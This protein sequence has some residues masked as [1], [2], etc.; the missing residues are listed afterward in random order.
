MNGS[1]T[2]VTAEP[3]QIVTDTVPTTSG[4]HTEITRKPSKTEGMATSYIIPASGAAAVFVAFIATLALCKTRRKKKGQQL[5]MSEA[6][7]RHKQS[8]IEELSAG[9]GISAALVIYSAF[10]ADI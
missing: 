4:N 3:R 5:S 1:R 9:R 8:R 2:F 10:V 7:T 6:R